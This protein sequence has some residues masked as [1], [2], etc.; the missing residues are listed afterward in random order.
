MP[1]HS[2]SRCINR[3]LSDIVLSIWNDRFPYLGRYGVTKE[4]CIN[5]KKL[6]F[7]D[8]TSCLL[9]CK[10]GLFDAVCSCFPDV[11]LDSHI[12]EIYQLKDVQKHIVE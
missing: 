7:L 10:L 4:V 6:L 3:P 1:I 12:F 8:Y 2:L 11:L 9:L 5:R